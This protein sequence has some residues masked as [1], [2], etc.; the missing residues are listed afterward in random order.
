MG[1]H[2]VCI[3]SAEEQSFIMSLTGGNVDAWMGAYADDNNQWRWVTGEEWDYT[4][5]R[6]GE[7][8]GFPN[9]RYGVVWP[10]TWNDLCEDSYEQG[11][12]ICEW[13]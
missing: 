1:G 3:T 6:E 13:E 9:E 8:N 10:E 12:Y 11:A 5:W 7:P 2:L 4:N